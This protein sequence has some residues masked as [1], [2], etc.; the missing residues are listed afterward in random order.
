[1]DSGTIP[2]A[3][4]IFSFFGLYPLS[5]PSGV[6]SLMAAY[7]STTSVDLFYLITP[8]SFIQ[9]ILA[10]LGMFM[11]SLQF[12]RNA[13]FAVAVSAVFTLTT[14]Y[15]FYTHQQ[16]STRGL[17]ISLFPLF[18]WLMFKFI[19]DKSI[20][21]ISLM[22]LFGFILFTTHRM[23]IFVLVIIA[24]LTLGYLLHTFTAPIFVSH[25][26]A[27]RRVN[28]ILIFLSIAVLFGMYFFTE[29]PFLE[30]IWDRTPQE[31]IGERSIRSYIVAMG[32]NYGKYTG[33]FS[34]FAPFG[35]L[36][37]LF[38]RKRHIK[39]TVLLSTFILFLFFM[40]GTLYVAIVL[41]PL[42]SI[43]IV[44]ALFTFKRYIKTYRSKKISVVGFMVFLITASVLPGIFLYRDYDSVHPYW[45]ADSS[46]EMG[47]YQKSSQYGTIG[48]YIIARQI[49]AFTPHPSGANLERGYGS[50]DRYDFDKV[51]TRSIRKFIEYPKSLFVM[52]DW[53]W[54][55]LPYDPGRVQVRI[56][57]RH[58]DDPEVQN[59]ID[60]NDVRYYVLHQGTVRNIMNSSDPEWTRINVRN[61]V[62]H[63]RYSIYSNSQVV[64]YWL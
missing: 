10:A 15:N 64:V 40:G 44:Y 48:H 37:L 23:G 52:E 7:S 16:I 26:K 55:G 57:R 12:K 42:L 45:M 31:I 51:E 8:F 27:G 3:Q 59:W 14:R 21:N 4:S 54:S 6:H 47:F 28:L 34:I 38:N 46:F 20:Q 62:P 19:E 30:M 9:S 25:K 43:F 58:I 60:E 56:Y 41:L 11:A 33:L 39:E 32:Y 17:F 18:L 29:I 36:L 49:D 61:T 53:Y 22:F 50:I 5:M 24:G 2:G 63:H 1:M 35:F 13:Y